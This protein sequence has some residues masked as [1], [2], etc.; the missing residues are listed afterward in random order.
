MGGGDVCGVGGE[1]AAGGAGAAGEP[2]AV[3]CGA[4]DEAGRV[5]R[6][7]GD[8]LAGVEGVTWEMAWWPFRAAGWC[9]TAPADDIM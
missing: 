5:C 7:G 1:R 9:S 8:A 4:G 6:G 2:G 3:A